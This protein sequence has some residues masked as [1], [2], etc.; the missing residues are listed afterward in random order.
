MNDARGEWFFEDQG[1]AWRPARNEKPRRDVVQKT[2]EAL[3]NGPLWARVGWR[4]ER[5][6]PGVFP[7][8]TWRSRSQP[9]MA[10]S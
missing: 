8:M 4:R 1:G 7:E 10:L 3:S 9:R 6:R 2:D 5:G